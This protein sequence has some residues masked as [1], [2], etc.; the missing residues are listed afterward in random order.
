M[1]RFQ[2][3]S[4]HLVLRVDPAADEWLA[5]ARSRAHEAPEAMRALLA[6]RSRVE[7]DPAEA[8]RALAWAALL[9][10]WHEDGRPPLFVHT[11]GEIILAG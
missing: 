7:V 3:A 11:P 9:Q 5:A 10:G 8:E 1:N 6:G 4:P 2:T